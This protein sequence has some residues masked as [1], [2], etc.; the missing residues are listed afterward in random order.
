MKRLD[1]TNN[2]Q[3]MRSRL[4]RRLALSMVAASFIAIPFSSFAG[5]FISVAIAPPPLPIYVQPIMP[6]PGY[7]WSPGYWSYA[8]D[9]GYF[10]VPGTWVLAPYVG[11]L[12]T[13]GYWG[14]SSGFYVFHGGYW[15]PHVGFYGGVNYGF[16]YTGSG[17]AGGYWNH[18]AFNYNRSVNNINVT[19]VHNVYNTTVI[20][21][22]T[23]NRVSYNGGAGGVS[24]QPTPQDAIAMRDT[25]MQPVAAQQQQMRMAS[26]N[27][28]LRAS[29]NHGAPAIAATP[30]PGA[31][32]GRGV[33]MARSAS[34]M[35]NRA[36]SQ[37][38][39]NT[40]RSASF[41]PHTANSSAAPMRSASYAHST[42]PA[43]QYQGS[44]RT[45][46]H[47]QPAA[48]ANYQPAAHSYQQPQNQHAQYQRPAGQP[49]PQ[50]HASAA[51]AHHSSD[52]DHH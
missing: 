12:W 40:Q 51:P 46:S 35:N 7:I 50:Q 45:A 32:S 21:N 43:G 39:F 23:I 28:A 15:G 22:T 44:M 19:N 9:G 26:Q 31:F 13:P 17:Y 18:G 8:D 3:T 11:A 25:H 52:H 6:G 14:W 33:V 47:Y 27:Q 24:A 1:C 30:R 34:P 37:P 20:N 38:N 16:G 5:V 4:L 10:W 29:V 49:R 36:M 42:Q 41:A 48:H 2:R